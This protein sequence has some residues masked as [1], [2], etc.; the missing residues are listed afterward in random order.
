MPRPRSRG[1]GRARSGSAKMDPEEAAAT[2]APEQEAGAPPQ[3]ESAAPEE[4]E[5]VAAPPAEEE[6]AAPPAEEEIA[7]PPAEKEIAAPPADEGNAGPVHEESAA[8][9]DEVSAAPVDGE[10]AAPVDG[11][12]AAPVDGESADAVAV[13]D[14]GASG[15]E[16]ERARKELERKVTELSIQNEHL[17]SQIAAAQ[18]PASS[19]EVGRGSVPEDEEG[20][21]LVRSLKEQVQRLSRE[22]H[23]QKQ[24][25]KVAEAALEHVNLSYA[26]AD[27]KVQELTAKLNQ[28]QLKL[29]KELKERDDKYVELDTKFQRLHKRAKQRIQDIQKEKDDLEARFN[30][31]N[32]KAEQAASLQVAAQQELERARH[33]ASEALRAMDAERQ[34]LRT[35]NSKLRSNF[36]ETRLAL[37]AR[38]NAL[39]K[40]Q[41]SMLEKEQMLEQIQGSMQSAEEKRHASVSELA[42]KHQKQL[43]SLEAQL[44]EVSAERT[45][46]SETIHSLQMVLAEKDTEIT[47]IEA[48]S[49]GEAARLK[50]TLE[51]IKGELAHLKGQHEKERQLW[52]AEHESLKEKL[53]ASESACRRSEIESDK[54]RCQL[55]SEL[56]RQNQLLQTKG[57][58]LISAKE[59]I[60]RL[61]SEFSAYKIRAHALLQKKDA[62]LST[63]QNSDLVKAHEEAIREAEKE[64]AAALEERDEA[65]QD[66]QAAQSRHREE[67]E[68]RDLALADV[69]KKLKNVMKTL[70]SVTSQFL[71]EKESWE[72]DL[73][74]LEESWRLKCESMKDQSNGHVEDHLQKNLGEWTLKYEKLKEEH[75]SFR[76][77]SDRMIEEK[78]REIAK[79]LKE[80]KDLHHSLEAKAAV[81]NGENQSPGHVK[82][83]VLSIELAEQQILLLARQQA[84]REEELGQSQRH[85]LALQQE[86]EELERENRLHDQQQAMLKTELR[87]MERSQKREGID[88]TYLKNVI[89]KLLETGEV[90]ALLPVVATLL[91]FSPDELN[92]CQHGVLSTVASSP[93]TALSDGGSTP[94][95][96]FGRFT[97]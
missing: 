33:Q 38:N 28:A 96:F 92:K 76:D 36:D 65:I 94:N 4:E 97:F 53:E 54:V 90:G 29:E 2:P 75:E 70:D 9:A 32:Q 40:L 71:S 84:Q 62:E 34:Q 93:A 64:V 10:R 27:G 35:V 85:I 6:I 30:E 79:L 18:Q 60:S 73:A 91:Q 19:A 52:E 46:A 12:R 41:Q 22:V 8:P 72:K 78:E 42:T 80:N 87:N 5:E 48:A 67:I 3:E 77:I 31:I 14:E 61:E 23:E 58:D 11:E 74:S 88:M 16:A 21:E 86:I 47:E 66:L 56:S 1:R 15:S 59:E 95:S 44:A 81:S 26:E 13:E 17:K 89:L 39:E 24:T 55:E 83:D 7:A 57:C 45:K 25:Q 69:D 20:S 82:Q 68:A 49:T 50:A 43:E 37:E 63:A 51:E